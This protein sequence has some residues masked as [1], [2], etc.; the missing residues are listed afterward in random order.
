[1]FR[2]RPHHTNTAVGGDVLFA[3]ALPPVH[4]V[5][6]SAVLEGQREV[7][8]AAP[9]VGAAPVRAQLRRSRLP[10]YHVA[11]VNQLERNDIESKIILKVRC[12]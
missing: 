12:Q 11:D 10:E 7:E 1:M 2:V 5:T 3:R 6:L 4:H 9:V 8:G